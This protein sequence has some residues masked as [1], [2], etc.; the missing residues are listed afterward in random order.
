MAKRYFK[1]IDILIA[2]ALLAGCAHDHAGEGHDH[3]AETAEGSQHEAGEIIL[4]PDK[5]KEA[6]VTVEAVASS[7]FSDVVAVSGR[8]LPSQS[9]IST[10]V[11]TQPG[12]VTLAKGWTPGMPVAAGTPLFHISQK[13]LP[14]GDLATRARID[15]DKARADYERVQKLYAEHLTAASEYE[16]AKAAYESARQSLDA[17]TAGGSGNVAATKGGFVLQ[18][19]VKDGDFVETGTPLM[20]VTATRRLQLQADVP[21][22]E[23]SRISEFTS[24]NFRMPQSEAL[25]SLSSLNGRVVSHSP[26]TEEGAPY[27]SLVFEFDNAPGVVAGSFAEVYLLGAPREGVISVPRSAVTEEQGIFY[28]YTRE[29]TDAYRKRRVATGATDGNRIEIKEGLKGGETVVATGATAV[30]LASM[31]TAIPGHTHEH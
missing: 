9:G 10:V 19:L 31:S 26:M 21:L 3:E 8:V 2:G 12:I 24:A 6:G 4:S 27:V 30:R 5:A 18:C 29:E 22:R 23:A 15:L 7:V 28:V 11:A 1:V 16:A 17:L 14:E 13:R 25:Y 20:T